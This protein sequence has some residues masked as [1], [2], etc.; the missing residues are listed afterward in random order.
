MKTEN[1]FDTAARW[2]MLS[3]VAMLISWLAL[4]AMGKEFGQPFLT[5]ELQ[6]GFAIMA[7]IGLMVFRIIASVLFIYWLIVA[8]IRTFKPQIQRPDEE[9]VARYGDSRD[10]DASLT[11][12]I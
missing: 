12:K 8:V 6:E 2:G 5:K 4:G 1:A 7:F 9:R 3:F 11:H 10:V